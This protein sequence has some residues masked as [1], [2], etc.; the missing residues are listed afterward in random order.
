MFPARSHSVWRTH[1]VSAVA[2]ADHS[3]K[4]RPLNGRDK[5]IDE[6]R[7]PRGFSMF[8]QPLAGR[9]LGYHARPCDTKRHGTF[10]DCPS[11]LARCCSNRPG[12]ILSS[13]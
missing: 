11:P 7:Y 6:I 4:A 8:S 9:R 2:Y 5:T 12:N 13:A 1:A 10:T 3:S